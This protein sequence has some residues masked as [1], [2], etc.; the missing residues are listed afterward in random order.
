MYEYHA[1]ILSVYDGDTMRMDIDVGFGVTLRDQ[2]VRLA[3]VDTP[4]LR[5]KEREAGLNARDFVRKLVLRRTV[6][7][8]TFRDTTGKFGRW[9][10]KVW[11][12]P[13]G[14]KVGET[15]EGLI[16]LNDLLIKTGHARGY[17]GESRRAST[18]VS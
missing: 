17:D 9:V 14:E 7:V 18:A 1:R 3:G 10:V 11:I 15:T 13:E 12:A 8:Q 6:M 4:E 2:R 16:L 5:G